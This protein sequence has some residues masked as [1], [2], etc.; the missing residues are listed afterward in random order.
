ML[1]TVRKLLPVSFSILF[2]LFFAGTVPASLRAQ[3]GYSAQLSGVISDSSGGGVP[4]VKVTL[5]DEDTGIARTYATDNRGIYVFT[6]V[7]PATYTIRVE[8]ANFATQERKGLT[9]AVSQQASLD[10]SLA[11]K[12]VTEKVV[13]TEQAPLLDTGNASLGTDVTNEYVRDIPLVNR[14]FFSLVFLAGGVT[15]TAG[16]GTE[17]SY[18]SGTNFVSNGQRN[19]TRK[20]ASMGLL[21]ARLNKAR[22]QRQTSTISHRSK[23]FRSS[24]SKITAFQRSTATTEELS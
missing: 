4:E 13:V 5:V 12:T 16:Q 22:A 18:P 21:Q 23:L 14:S 17:D 7:R 19:A 3:S 20:C 24:R 15:E 8:S 11:P 10:F 2:V 1:Q 6:G 9:L